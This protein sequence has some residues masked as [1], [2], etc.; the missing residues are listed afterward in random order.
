MMFHVSSHQVEATAQLPNEGQ[1][2]MPSLK[3]VEAKMLDLSP[4]RVPTPMKGKN[5]R[6]FVPGWVMEVS[7]SRLH[8]L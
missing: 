2:V 3:D 8:A 7:G 5:L 1:L 4:L 6:F